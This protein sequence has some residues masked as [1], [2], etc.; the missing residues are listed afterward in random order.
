ME[1]N[2]NWIPYFENI[3]D[4]INRGY[5]KNRRN[6]PR[7][8][9]ETVNKVRLTF[10]KKRPW[11]KGA[12]TCVPPLIYTFINALSRDN[13]ILAM[14]RFFDAM[15]MEIEIPENL[16]FSGVPSWLPFSDNTESYSAFEIEKFW[17]FWNVALQLADNNLSDQQLKNKF[18]RLFDAL[19]NLNGYRLGP[20]NSYK[21]TSL[22]IILY[23]IR[24]EQYLPL[25]QKTRDYLDYL[26]IKEWIPYSAKTKIDAVKYLSLLSDIHSSLS[27]GGLFE[28][29]IHSIPE[30]SYQAHLYSESLPKKGKSEAI[31]SKVVQENKVTQIVE[32]HEGA[33]KYGVD[34]IDAETFLPKR[35][36]ETV[37]RLLK[38]RK[39]IILQGPPGTGKTFL[40]K[41]IAFALLGEKATSRIKIIQFHPS[42]SYEDFI[43]GYRPL[44]DGFEL[45][46]GLFYS[47]CKE[48][49]REPE[50]KYVFIIDEINRGNLSKI[51]GELMMLLEASHRGEEVRLPYKCRKENEEDLFFSVPKNVYLI[52]TMNTADRSI[53]MLDYALRRRFSFF[54]IDPLFNEKFDKYF[55]NVDKN[56]YKLFSDLIS[57]IKDINAAEIA[58]MLGKGFF[59]GH[60]YFCNL[61]QKDDPNEFRKHLKDIVDYEVKPMLMEYWFDNSATYE[62]V[63]KKLD[64]C[65]TKK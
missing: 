63:C 37:L 33:S 51:F 39:N 62:D 59:I 11:T 46:D 38:Y 7:Q 28:K 13:R 47:F 50:K 21:P 14:R 19:L 15:S 44:G 61:D 34:D 12:D 65:F 64:Q 54:E 55:A 24:P 32:L 60:S 26:K 20:G 4:E 22:S 8:L 6:F 41:K 43:I 58:K 49:K 48:A 5:K 16:D 42:Y 57:V 9:W 17:E 25:D 10:P 31:S 45:S 30:L 52:G 27:S 35:D 1:S 36:I 2:F 18:E 53:A 29:G 56:S 3:A 40:A 23:Y